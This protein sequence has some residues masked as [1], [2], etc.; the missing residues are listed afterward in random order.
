MDSK[1][2][3]K[4]MKSPSF[5]T[6]KIVI[7]RYDFV[8]TEMV[9]LSMAKGAEYQLLDTS[10]KEWWLVRNRFG[11]EGFV[12]F[13]YVEE[14]PLESEPYYSEIY[15]E[16]EIESEHYYYMADEEFNDLKPMSLPKKLENR[17]KLDLPTGVDITIPDNTKQLAPTGRDSSG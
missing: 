3:P 7:A 14:K 12:P 1:S 15:D 13:N 4:E 6:P 8:G 11:G 16:V 2:Y 17:P 5:G 9:E 10:D